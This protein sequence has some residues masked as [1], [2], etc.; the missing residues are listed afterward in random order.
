M[1]IW[2]LEP[3][4][5]CSRHLHQQHDDV[6]ALYTLLN[7]PIITYAPPEV[8]RWRDKEALLHLLH[9]NIVIEL[10]RRGYSHYTPLPRQK[11]LATHIPEQDV[12][13]S[14]I[15]EQII[16]LRSHDCPCFL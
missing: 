4:L 10:A 15:E 7:Q 13:V 6:H 16:V 1:Q 5:L 3:V 12:F 8:A 11:L 9:D 14:T 2:D